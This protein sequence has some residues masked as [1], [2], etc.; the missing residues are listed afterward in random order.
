[1]CPFCWATLGLIVAG[2]FSTGGQAALAVKVSRKKN[3]TEEIDPNLKSIEN[4]E[5]VGSRASSAGP[6]V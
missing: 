1:M 3:G 6:F 2:T 4:L 5:T